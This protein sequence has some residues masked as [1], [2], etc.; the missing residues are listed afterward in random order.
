LQLA[1]HTLKGAVRYFFSGDSLEKINRLE[2]M[3]RENSLGG[4]Q[5]ILAPL[6]EQMQLLI[7][8]LSEYPAQ[9]QTKDA[10]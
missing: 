9:S 1:A 3:G 4:A 6:E 8:A 5:E 2:E 7:R 10:S